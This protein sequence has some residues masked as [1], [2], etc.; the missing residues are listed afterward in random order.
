MLR[1]CFVILALLHFV[2][3]ASAAGKPIIF[4]FN[5]PV[6]PDDSVLVTGADLDAVTAATINRLPD[7]GATAEPEAAITIAIL[8]ANPQSLKFIVPK[9]FAPG[10][11]RFTL[12]SAEGAVSGDINRPTIYWIQGNL[13]Q[14]AAPG[15][16]LQIFGR[17]IVRQPDRARLMLVPD[18]AGGPVAATLS[19]GGIWR[20]SFRVPDAVTPGAYRARLSNGDGG[21]SEWVDAGTIQ[22]RAPVPGPKLSVDVRSFGAFGDGKVNSTR[23]VMTAL[24]A[25]HRG[26]GGTVYFPRGRYLITEPLVIPPGV[27]IKGERTD[28]VNLVWPDFPDA[29]DALIK[30]TSH[31]SIEDVTIYASNHGHIV[32]GGFIG[33]GQAPDASD[34]AIRRVRIRASAFRGHM[35]AQETFQRMTTLHVRYPES[36]DSIRLSGDRLVVSDCDIVGSGRSLYLF[37]ASNAVIS[38]NILSNGRFGWYSITGSSRVIFENNVVTAADLQGTGGGIN[39]LSSAV[40]A[41]EDIFLG[42]N[43]FKNM[44]GWDRE[45][46]T[47]DGPGGYYFGHAQS[48]AP[49]RLS[50]LGALNEQL[51]SPNW[52]GAVVMVVDGAGAGQVASVKEFEQAAGSQQMSITLDRPLQVSLGANS[53][54]TVAQMQ[55]NY[56][57][58]DNLFEDS[59]VAAQTYG[60]ALNHVFAGNR[61]VRTG[62][63]FL[64]GG[65]YFHFQAG[66]QLQLLDN[67]IIEGNVYQ[68][69]PD[70]QVSSGEAV[71][72]I[73]GRQPDAKQGRPALLRAIVVRGN[74]LEQDSHIEIKGV[75]VA[76]P[77][78]RDIIVEANTI[79]ASRVGLSMDRAIAGLVERRNIVNR[80]AR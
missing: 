52:T 9:D 37:K 29:P 16:W 69:G 15:E 57:I 25:A 7:G 73:Y 35:T 64:I 11:Y 28:L 80:I 60:T 68:A 58:I 72:G 43:T 40:A 62:G 33:N 14:A 48:A 71:V 23:A 8:Q 26:G 47:T 12:S 18:G 24:E 77:G 27:S 61:S 50:L 22:I 32:S 65:L 53:V 79:G 19:E 45:A 76:S 13:G 56:L 51:V 55:Q 30:G 6:G 66:W 20:A 10:I 67:Q 42:H 70:R 39:T 75:S 41:S 78:I 38:G 59:G 2:A 46:M 49:D 4:W 1:A 3:V 34:I 63:F 21:D 36:P 44:I 31:F 5:D 74:R 54:I 17:N